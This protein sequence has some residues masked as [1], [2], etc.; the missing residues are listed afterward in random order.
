MKFSIVKNLPLIS[1]LQPA[2]II[3]MQK[4]SIMMLDFGEIKHDLFYVYSGR[5][6]GGD[7]RLFK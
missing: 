4:T 1:L 6:G 7:V 3:D 5:L 2:H